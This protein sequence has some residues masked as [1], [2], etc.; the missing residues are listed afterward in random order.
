MHESHWPISLTPAVLA[1][2]WAALADLPWA[3]VFSVLGIALTAIG[4]AAVK[5]WRDW[6]L[7]QIEIKAR[8]R[9]LEGRSRG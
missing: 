2:L 3:T 1:A 6:R 8:R 4:P 9:D 5:T 7:A